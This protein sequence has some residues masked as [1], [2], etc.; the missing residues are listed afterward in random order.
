MKERLPL[1]LTDGRHHGPHKVKRPTEVPPGSDG[2]HA[3]ARHVGLLIAPQEVVEVLL[4]QVVP[5][6]EVLEPLRPALLGLALL[7][8]LQ[9]REDGGAA[10][11]VDDDEQR[12]QQEP[13]VVLVHRTA[14][15]GGGAAAAAVPAGHYGAS[16]AVVARACL[17]V[18]EG[19]RSAGKK[20]EKGGKYIKVVRKRAIGARI[21]LV[22]RSGSPEDL[23]PDAYKDAGALNHPH[24]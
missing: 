16:V 4:A 1:R 19:L 21:S 18:A 7:G 14:G 24:G 23:A 17:M 2:V 13:R 9:R 22:V 11:Q 10:Q 12:Q 15:G 5:L 20:T 8:L 3:D 6:A